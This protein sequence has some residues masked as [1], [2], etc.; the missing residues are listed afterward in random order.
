MKGIQISLSPRRL[1]FKALSVLLVLAILAAA[2]PATALA[3]PDAATCSTN[4]IVKSGDTLSSIALTYKV[5]TAE[6]AAANNLKEPYTLY[7]GQAL[8]IPGTPA[9]TTTSTTSGSNPNINAT[10][11]ATTATFKLSGLTKKGVF[12][13]K[14]RKYDR[15][16]TSWYRF[17]HFVANKNGG[18]TVTVK[19]PRIL[20]E[21]GEI[22]IC[23]KNAKNDKVWCQRFN[24]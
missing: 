22:Q 2:L 23:F 24:K 17:G 20:R 15:N 5:T 16:D 7:I 11:T 18:G 21:P 9:T 8:C 14:G 19:L 12:V 1:G 6:L 4:Y 10:F 13:I 3:A